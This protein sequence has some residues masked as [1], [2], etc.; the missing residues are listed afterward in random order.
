MRNEEY[1]VLG[2]A[3]LALWFIVKGKKPGVW[4]MPGVSDNLTSNSN[5][6]AK[7]APDYQGW[8]FFSDGVSISPEGKYYLNGVMVYPG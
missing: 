3:G 7:I 2:L 1:L 8:Q 6:S 5:W 4:G